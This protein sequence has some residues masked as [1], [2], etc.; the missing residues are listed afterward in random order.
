[1]DEPTHVGNRLKQARKKKGYTLD[2]MQQLTKI[3][4]RYLIAIEENRLEDL[5]GEFFVSNFIRQYADVVGITLNDEIGR[6][7]SYQDLQEPKERSLPTRSELKRSSREKKFIYSNDAKN[8]LPTFLL[9]LMFLFIL[10][11]I[12]FY[13]FYMKGNGADSNDVPSSQS[14]QVAQSSAESS[15]SVESSEE[16]EV[17]QAGTVITASTEEADSPTYIITGLDLP[18]TLAIEVNNTGSSWVSVTT[19]GNNSIFEGTIP[20]G[21]T[22]TEE[23][24]EGVNQIIIRVGYLPSTTIKFGDTSVTLPDDYQTNQTQTLIFNLE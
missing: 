24:A 14:Q 17:P 6:G 2:D 23:L 16:V 11:S 3:Q 21:T 12:W 22:Q 7:Y 18:N 19:D 13:T 10:G 20:G 15:E 8:S 9:V 1:M 5:P 4:K